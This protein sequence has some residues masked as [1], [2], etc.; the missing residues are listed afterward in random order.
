MAAAGAHNGS[1]S[2]LLPL[3]LS[4]ATKAPNHCNLVELHTEGVAVLHREET[5]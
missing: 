2:A 1:S 4:V 5:R 3:P